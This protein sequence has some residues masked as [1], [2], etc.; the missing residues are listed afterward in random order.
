M[1]PCFHSGHLDLYARESETTFIIDAFHSERLKISMNLTVRSVPSDPL[2]VPLD[3]TKVASATK[4][5]VVSVTPAPSVLVSINEKNLSRS[6]CTG[7]GTVIDGQ[8]VD[9]ILDDMVETLEGP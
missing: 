2:K 5:S 7:L 3:E 8:E 1:F 4:I 9:A 6:S